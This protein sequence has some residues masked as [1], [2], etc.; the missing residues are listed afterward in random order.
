MQNPLKLVWGEFL[1]PLLRR[2]GRLQVAALCYRNGKRG[3]EVLVITSR[4]TGR[5]IIPKGW[6]MRGKESN[7]AALQEA[8]EEA[9]V[10]TGRAP[11]KALG[12][13]H[14]DK[15]ESGGWSQPVKALVYPVEVKELADK[16]PEVTER[17]RKWV[18]PDEA[19]N[20][21]AE[22]E[23]KKLLQEF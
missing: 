5:W 7:E 20:L 8:W 10:R 2:P 15:R 11:T 18:S 13:F 1:S 17:K 19:A 14:Y 9:G 12:H 16:F 3:R 22:P 6:P 23:L 4:D 21:V